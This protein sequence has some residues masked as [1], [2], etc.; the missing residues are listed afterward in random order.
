MTPFVSAYSICAISPT[1]HTHSDHT[2]ITILR[3]HTHILRDTQH[4][5]T[6]T[7]THTLTFHFWEEAED[8]VGSTMIIE[9]WCSGVT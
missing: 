4:T 9:N 7:H 6:H 1:H 5:H 8:R 2:H 3:T